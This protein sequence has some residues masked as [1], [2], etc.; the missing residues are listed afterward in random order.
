MCSQFVLIAESEP[1]AKYKSECF[2][3]NGVIRI[4]IICNFIQADI[5]IKQHINPYYLN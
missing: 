1:G 5:F 4:V 2:P 3:F